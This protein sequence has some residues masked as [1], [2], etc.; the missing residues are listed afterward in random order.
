MKRPIADNFQSRKHDRFSLLRNMQHRRHTMI[1]KTLYA[2]VVWCEHSANKIKT[3]IS[4]ATAAKA[5][6]RATPK[7]FYPRFRLCFDQMV[8]R[9]LEFDI[10]VEAV[11][12]QLAHVKHILQIGVEAYVVTPSVTEELANS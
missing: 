11:L 12:D 9:I 10:N 3:V 2:H 4:S 7:R 6:R 1:K 5:T 8:K